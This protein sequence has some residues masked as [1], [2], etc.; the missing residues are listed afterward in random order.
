MPKIKYQFDSKTLTFKKVKLAWRQKVKRALTV[1]SVTVASSLFLHFAYTSFYNTP[2]EEMLLGEKQELITKY[3]I[4]NDQFKDIDFIIRDIQQRD[5]Y[6]YRT[7]FELEPIPASVRSAGFGGTN[8]YIDLEGFE[9]SSVMIET[10]KRLDIISKKIYV[11]SK[12]FDTVIELA[13]NKEKMIAAIPAI[14][15]LALKDF[16]RIS[17][18]FGARNDPFTGKRTMHHG[19]DFTGPEGSDIFATGDGVVIEAGYNSHGYGNKIMI[20]HG[21]GYKTIYA[22]LQKVNVDIGQK[23]KRGDVIGLLGNTGRSTGAHL[24]YEVRLYNKMINPINYYFNDMSDE[25]YD[26]MVEA[27]SK[28]RNPMD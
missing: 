10:F 27:C 22:H 3:E 7:I 17:D 4:L 6:F 13:K 20:D 19:M 2:K 28:R 14:Q 9:S 23:V 18:Y 16:N 24:H 11:Q 25:E 21:Y 26:L 12:S 15:P 5:D 1:L 8:R